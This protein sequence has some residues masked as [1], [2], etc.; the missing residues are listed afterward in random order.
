M[1]ASITNVVTAVMI[2]HIRIVSNP[3]LTPP[4]RRNAKAASKAV[5]EAN[6]NGAIVR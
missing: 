6:A 2:A 3:L 4:H 5:K 1:I